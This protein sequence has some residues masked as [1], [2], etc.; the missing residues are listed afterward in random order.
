METLIQVLASHPLQVLLAGVA[1]LHAV[2]LIIQGHRQRHSP[3]FFAAR[4]VRRPAS[5]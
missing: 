2:D 4:L 1:L 3:R 5:A